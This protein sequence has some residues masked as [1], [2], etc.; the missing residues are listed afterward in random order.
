M[1]LEW[2]DDF[3][4]NLS[5]LPYFKQKLESDTDFDLKRTSLILVYGLVVD[6]D[7]VINHDVSRS[8]TKPTKRCAPCENSYQPGHLP[9]LIRVFAVCM[10]KPRV[11]SYPVSA[12]QRLIRLG[13]CPGWS[14]SSLGTQV[15][16]LVLPWCG[17][18]DLISSVN[19][20][21][22]FDDFC[23]TDKL[24]GLKISGY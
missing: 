13:G 12:Q 21:E 23:H 17:S 20:A 7:A 5:F 1:H 8:M 18:C 2:H 10:K 9:S 6:F 11:L 15:I 3:F 16:L 14:E 19:N 4:K 22:I 24:A